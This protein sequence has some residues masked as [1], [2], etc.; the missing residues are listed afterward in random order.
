MSADGEQSVRRYLAAAFRW[1]ARFGFHEGTANHFRVF[2]QMRESDRYRL[3]I[4]MG[5]CELYMVDN[6]R[7]MHGRTGFTADG[8]RHLQSC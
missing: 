8:L 6:R 1:A 5:R 2:G 7:V 3:Q 4:E